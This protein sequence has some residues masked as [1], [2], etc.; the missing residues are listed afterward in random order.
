MSIRSILK[1][2]VGW[3]SLTVGFSMLGTSF[4]RMKAIVLYLRCVISLPF[5]FVNIHS[6]SCRI[7]RAVE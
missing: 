7:P 6:R 3:K 5:S 2:L 4:G 1:L